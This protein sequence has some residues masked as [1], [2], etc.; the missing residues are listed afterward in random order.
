MSHRVTP[1]F[2]N[3]SWADLGEWR[4]RSSLSCLAHQASATIAAPLNS[5]NNASRIQCFHDGL[6]DL[7]LWWQSSDRVR[8]QFIGITLLA[9]GI[10][11]DEQTRE[12][13]SRAAEISSLCQISVGLLLDLRED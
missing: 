1:R 3:L 9:L 13:W 4:C 7:S 5:R 2:A 8:H 6:Q 11:I 10:P 12:I